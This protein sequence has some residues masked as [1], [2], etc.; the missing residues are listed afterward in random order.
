MAIG[1]MPPFYC[2]PEPRTDDKKEALDKGAYVCVHCIERGPSLTTAEKVY[3]KQNQS[4]AGNPRYGAHNLRE[5]PAAVIQIACI[6]EKDLHRVST[7]RNAI[8]TKT[9]TASPQGARLSACSAA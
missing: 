4:D 9:R 3:R 7:H 5:Y 8:Q 6:G 1:W 2:Q